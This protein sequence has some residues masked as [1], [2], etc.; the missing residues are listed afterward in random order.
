MSTSSQDVANDLADGQG[1]SEFAVMAQE[2]GM[3]LSYTDEVE[4]MLVDEMLITMRGRSPETDE[5][6]KKAW[7]ELHP[8]G[9]YVQGGPEVAGT[10]LLGPPGHGKT[11]VMRAAAKKV[12]ELLELTF[13]DN[14]T[15]E[16]E[17]TKDCFLF[18]SL[19]FAGVNSAIQIKG[20][21]T[22][23]IKKARIEARSSVARGEETSAEVAYLGFLKDYSLSMLSKA[24]GSVLL[25]DDLLNATPEMINVALPLTEEKRFAGTHIT[26]TYVGATGNL[27]ARDGTKTSGM[28][29]ALSGRLRMKMVRDNWR[30][31]ARRARETY[32]GSGE[33]GQFGTMYFDSYLKRFGAKV[34]EDLPQ[35]EHMGNYGS[36]RTFMK[37]MAAQFYAV[38]AAGGR[39]H[40]RD[41]LEQMPD[42]VGVFLGPVIGRDL[43]AFMMSA[44]EDADPAARLLI[45]EGKVHEKYA[46]HQKNPTGPEGQ[47]FFHQMAEAMADYAARAVAEKHADYETILQRFGMALWDMEGPPF[48]MAL[49]SFKDRLL[50]LNPDMAMPN[51][52]VNKDNGQR[53]G[54]TMNEE[55]FQRTYKTLLACPNYSDEKRS[56]FNEILSENALYSNEAKVATPVASRE[57]AKAKPAST[58]RSSSP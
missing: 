10:C 52:K 2:L 15:D 3:S 29:R 48:G 4:D 23:M 46:H 27:G 55:T 50:Q 18:M 51:Q 21:P 33:M 30:S 42:R 39:D 16:V 56:Q 38:A 32:S 37:A 14:P 36:P 19:E 31:V 49:D 8:K 40:M 35:G 43:T 47:T 57:R 7:K 9:I 1:K 12:A 26:G 58:R 45:E 25:L 11:S 20:I 13:V 44:Y 24:G 34:I 22:K 6:I 54:L 17:I 28:T 5:K 41:T 53:G